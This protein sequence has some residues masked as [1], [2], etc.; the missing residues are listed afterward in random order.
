MNTDHLAVELTAKLAAAKQKL[1][2]AA[3]ACL[4]NEPGAADEA[5]RALAE[6]ASLQAMLN[7]QRRCTEPGCGRVTLRDKCDRHRA[8]DIW[9]EVRGHL[10][11]LRQDGDE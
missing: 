2:R 5:D 8:P 10:E 9:D 11:R 3:Q 4:R 6:V 7:M 1:N